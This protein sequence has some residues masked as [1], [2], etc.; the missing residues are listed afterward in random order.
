MLLKDI[1]KMEESSVSDIKE[2]ELTDRSNEGGSAIDSVTLNNNDLAFRQTH[3]D[4]NSSFEL[5]DTNR[6]LVKKKKEKK[7]DSDYGLD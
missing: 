2:E 7:S 4:R 5:V 1:I 3:Q 6:A